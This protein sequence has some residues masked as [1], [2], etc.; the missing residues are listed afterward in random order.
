MA[1]KIEKDDLEEIAA[2]LFGAGL[3]KTDYAR[4]FD[5]HRDTYYKWLD[6]GAPR[7][8]IVGIAAV[9]ALQLRK[10]AGV[11]ERLALGHST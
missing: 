1:D 2:V 6:E 5:V 10:R 3:S 9:T 7:A 8:Q 4:A 11:L